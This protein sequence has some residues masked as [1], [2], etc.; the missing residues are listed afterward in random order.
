MKAIAARS[1]ISTTIASAKGSRIAQMD[2]AFVV[3][4]DGTVEAARTSTHRHGAHALQEAWARGAGP[5]RHQQVTKAVAVAVS[6]SNGTV[7]IFRRR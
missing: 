4:P 5:G 1:G 7:R 6:E 3:A 2:G